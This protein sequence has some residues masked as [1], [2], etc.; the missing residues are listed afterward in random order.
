M[1]IM[2]TLPVPIDANVSFP[3]LVHS[4]PSGRS[5]Y[6]DIAYGLLKSVNN[7]FSVYVLFTGGSWIAI[8]SVWVNNNGGPIIGSH[9]GGAIR[10]NRVDIQAQ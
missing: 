3:S 6:G 8:S 7:Y 10:M 2:S 9:L 5:V 4:S 1:N